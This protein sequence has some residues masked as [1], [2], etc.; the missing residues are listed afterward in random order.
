[1]WTPDPPTIATKESAARQIGVAVLAF[2]AFGFTMKAIAPERV[3]APRS[4]PYDGLKAELGGI[5]QNKVRRAL[6]S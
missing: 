3:S 6:L 2:V 1:M 4:Y 5:E